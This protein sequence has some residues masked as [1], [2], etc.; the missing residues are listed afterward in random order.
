MD[1]KFLYWWR[2]SQFIGCV[3]GGKAKFAGET[4]IQ[5]AT[6]QMKPGRSPRLSYSSTSSRKVTE[7]G[8]EKARRKPEAKIKI[9]RI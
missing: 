9:R 3:V 5:P 1:V 2:S 6:Y 7:D 8:T 4:G